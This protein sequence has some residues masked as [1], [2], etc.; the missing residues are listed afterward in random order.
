MTTADSMS[1]T[2]GCGGDAAAYALGAMDV[3]EGEEFRRHLTSCAVCR[4]ELAAFRLVVDELPMAAHQHPVPRGLRHRV[5]RDVRA[6][7]APVGPPAQRRRRTLF[8]GRFV[9]RPALAGALLVAVALAIVGGLDLAPSASS[10]TRVIQASVIGVAGEAQL[11]VAAGHAE[12][13][14]SHLPPPRPGGIYEVWIKRGHHAPAPTQTLFGVTDSGTAEVGVPGNV[15]GIS[16]IMVTQEPAGG[17]L[18]PTRAPVIVA[19][20]T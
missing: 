11:R 4:D 3:H 18:V 2:P 15:R 17:S 14:V 6:E 1:E 13:I 19:Q 16:T 5:M 9:S 7:P 12:L 10:G 20:L 8:T